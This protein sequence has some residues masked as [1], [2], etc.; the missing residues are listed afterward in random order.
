MAIVGCTDQEI[1]ASF[2]DELTPA[3]LD[4]IKRVRT[5]GA[6]QIPR[7]AEAQVA[8]EYRREAHRPRWMRGRRALLHARQRLASSALSAD[9]REQS[10][11]RP[12][13]RSGL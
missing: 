6:S 5:Y 10:L 7:P 3:L 2:P 13:R 1:A 8:R 12:L 11:G 4:H 9:L